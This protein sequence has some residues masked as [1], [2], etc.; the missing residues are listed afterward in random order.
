MQQI[1]MR[2][3]RMNKALAPPMMYHCQLHQILVQVAVEGVSGVGVGLVEGLGVGVGVGIIT[4]VDVFND[5]SGQKIM[6]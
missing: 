6:P 2:I 1:I 3:T 4:G 5:I